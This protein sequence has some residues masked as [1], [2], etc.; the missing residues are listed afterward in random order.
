MKASKSKFSSGPQTLKHSTSK[1]DDVSLPYII[2]LDSNLLF[3]LNTV[4]SCTLEEQNERNA[5]CLT[6]DTCRI[7]YICLLCFIHKNSSP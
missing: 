3:Y 7:K 5:H 2:F 6:K 4:V 1:E